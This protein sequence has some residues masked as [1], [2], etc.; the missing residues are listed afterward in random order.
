MQRRNLKDEK[1][2]DWELWRKQIMSLNWGKL[3]IHIKMY[4]YITWD[5]EIKV[6]IRFQRLQETRIIYSHPCI[7]FLSK[8]WGSDQEH[9]SGQGSEDWIIM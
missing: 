3:C 4:I 1:C 2:S 6:K 8:Y 7:S 5:S 9:P